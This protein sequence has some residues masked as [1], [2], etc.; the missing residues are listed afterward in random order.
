MKE[1]AGAIFSECMRYRYQLFRVWDRARPLA[2]CVG[3]NPST[4]NGATDDPTIK[5]L[6][7]ILAHQGYGGFYMT[8]LYA[9]ISSVP[10]KLY[11]VP[12]PLGEN[13]T[14]LKAVADLTTDVFL[15]WGS[16]KGLEVRIKSILKIVAGKPLKCFGKSSKGIPIHPAYYVRRGTP[17]SQVP[18]T[19]Y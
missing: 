16:F 6:R 13:D 5:K 7:R 1:K 12:D 15:C 14:H 18:I 9:L 17:E 4:A 10:D 2:M 11:S 3:L 8:N 19:T